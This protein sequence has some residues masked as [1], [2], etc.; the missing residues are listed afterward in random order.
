MQRIE[1]PALH[2][3]SFFKMAAPILRSNPCLLMEIPVS[4]DIFCFAWVMP[5]ARFHEN[6]SPGIEDFLLMTLV[7]SLQ[8][9][10]GY[11]VKGS[12]LSLSVPLHA[13]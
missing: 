1:I 13:I 11:T 2:S 6:E 9:L 10:S 12:S 7:G 4:R 3:S 5:R 8:F